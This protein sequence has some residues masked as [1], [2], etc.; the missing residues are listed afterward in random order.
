[1][2]PLGKSYTTI[3]KTQATVFGGPV[4]IK[5]IIDALVDIAYIYDDKRRY[6]ILSEDFYQA[7]KK[8]L[9]GRSGPFFQAL[10]DTNPE[11]LEYRNIKLVRVNEPDILL[12]D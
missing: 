3:T 8:Q 1:M 10:R 11:I 6:I 4:Q 7:L 5:G 2:Q 12:V 9:I